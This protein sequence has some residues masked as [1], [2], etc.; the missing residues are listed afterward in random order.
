MGAPKH[1]RPV[2]VLRLERALEP[3]PLVCGADRRM[4]RLRQPLL[5]SRLLVCSHKPC[6]QSS[7]SESGWATDGGFAFQMAA[8]AERFAQT[9]VLV[10]AR[11]VDSTTLL[12]GEVPLVGP[13]LSVRAVSMPAGTGIV[14]KLG[15]LPWTLRTMPEL[16]EGHVRRADVVHAPIPG[17][18]GTVALQLAIILRKPLFVRHCGNWNSPRTSAEYSWRWL[19]ERVAGRQAVV[20]ATGGGTDAPSARNSKILWIFS[21]SL[22]AAELRAHARER[23]LPTERGLRLVIASRQDEQKG[24]RVVLEALALIADRMPNAKFGRCR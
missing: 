7:D 3:G 20:M 15:M 11:K 18:I 13:R 17:D 10:P 21:T 19:L 22:T 1:E 5:E 24:T 16:S 23:V 2:D 4:T 9:E 14:R 12:A 6:W 8:L